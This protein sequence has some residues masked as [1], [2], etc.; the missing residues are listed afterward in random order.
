MKRLIKATVN[1][2]GFVI[3]AGT[4]VKREFVDGSDLVKCSSSEYGVFYTHFT[5]VK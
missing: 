1:S 4:Q 3:P 5:N 2:F